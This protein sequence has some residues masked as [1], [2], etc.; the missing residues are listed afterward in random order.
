[1]SLPK[2]RVE[3]QELE[4]A[5]RK[6][7]VAHEAANRQ[8]KIGLWGILL[9]IPLLFAFGIGAL[10][11]VAGALA[12]ITNASKRSTAEKDVAKL[13]EEI[14]ELRLRIAEAETE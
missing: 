9:G 1:M 10:F 11:I 13:N 3:L 14:K 8:Y 12:A 2:M 5:R 6:A 7:E 4:E